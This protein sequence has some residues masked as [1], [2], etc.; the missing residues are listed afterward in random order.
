V[1]SAT[2]IQYPAVSGGQTYPNNNFTLSSNTVPTTGAIKK[3]YYSAG[4][5][6]IAMRII[7]DGGSVLYYLHSDH[8]R[9]RGGRLWAARA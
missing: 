2:V 5:Q 9:L 8:P 7:T 1:L 3:V 4:A 6:L